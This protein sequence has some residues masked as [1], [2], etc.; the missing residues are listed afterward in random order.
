MAQTVQPYVNAER[1]KW[2]SLY[3]FLHN[4]LYISTSLEDIILMFQNWS[5]KVYEIYKKGRYQWNVSKFDVNPRKFMKNIKFRDNILYITPSVI[6]FQEFRSPWL[7]QPSLNCDTPEGQ[8][9]H[10]LGVKV[11][12]LKESVH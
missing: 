11:E 7:K 9:E 4:F 5:L 10:D 2:L 12:M 8:G 1:V 6:Q 3:K